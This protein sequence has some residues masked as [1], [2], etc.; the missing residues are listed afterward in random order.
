ML[1]ANYS[2]TCDKGQCAIS[3]EQIILLAEIKDWWFMWRASYSSFLKLRVVWAV[4]HSILPRLDQVWLIEEWICMSLMKP[5]FHSL[6]LAFHIWINCLH[7]VSEAKA[8]KIGLSYFQ[9][10]TDWF[11][12]L[13]QQIKSLAVC[14][15]CYSFWW[16]KSWKKSE[17]KQGA[18]GEARLGFMALRPSSSRL[19]YSW[20]VTFPFRLFLLRFL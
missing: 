6:V 5:S 2:S 17:G 13:W 9:Q 15:V 19:D 1:R 8:H 11:I 16:N 3:W 12:R 18:C 20:P 10:T 4:K 7:L 14:K